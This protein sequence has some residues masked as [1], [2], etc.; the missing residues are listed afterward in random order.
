[1]KTLSKARGLTRLLCTS[2][3]AAIV[4]AACMPGLSGSAPVSTA[5]RLA[6]FPSDLPW[7]IEQ[8]VEIRWQHNMIPFVEARTDADCAFAIGVVHA[9]LR[10]GQMEVFRRGSAGRL[11]ESLGPVVAPDIDILLRQLDLG[12]SAEAS[13][14]LLSAADRLWLQ[15]YLDGINFLV[16]N[17]PALPA[18]FRLLALKPETWTAVDSLRIARLGSGDPNWATLLS[19]LPLQGKPGWESLWQATL[20]GAAL[21]YPSIPADQEGGAGLEGAQQLLGLSART[22][23]NSLVVGGA[24]SARGAA[25]I[26]SDPHLGIFVPNLWLLMGYRCPSYEVLGYMLPGVPAVTLGRNRDIAWGGTAMRGI[27]SHLFEVG[28]ADLLPSRKEKLRIRAGGTARS[29]SPKA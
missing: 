26:A 18:E 25:L 1:M 12:R 6:G 15:R 28:D 2:F 27:S 5:E 17:S 16:A 3:L 20:D 29:K 23:S 24:R 4:T 22:G 10:L 7:P 11:A 19:L 9:Y 8:P 14:A 13:V 21:S